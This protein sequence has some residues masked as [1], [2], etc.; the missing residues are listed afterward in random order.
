MKVLVRPAYP[1]HELD[2]FELLVYSNNK[3]QCVTS[4]SLFCLQNLSPD[5]LQTATALE[6]ACL[7]A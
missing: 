1:A 2:L 7:A 6:S 4:S 3:V 5:A